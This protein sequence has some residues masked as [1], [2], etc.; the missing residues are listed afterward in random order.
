ME[1]P[2][3]FSCCL[4]LLWPFNCSQSVCLHFCN[5]AAFTIATLLGK[6][7]HS[8]VVYRQG[9]CGQ[10]LP[11]LDV[12]LPIPTVLLAPKILLQPGSSKH[13]FLFAMLVLDHDLSWRNGNLE[14]GSRFPTFVSHDIQS[15]QEKG[16]LKFALRSHVQFASLHLRN[17]NI[18]QSKHHEI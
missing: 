8:S 1:V 16:D 6:L 3:Q 2:C 18:A 5:E 7:K 17:L 14:H 13:T 15:K 4:P 9:T 11:H 12:T 10:L